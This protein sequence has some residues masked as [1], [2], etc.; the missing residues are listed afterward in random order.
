[1]LKKIIV[2][3]LHAKYLPLMLMTLLRYKSYIKRDWNDFFFGDDFTSI[4]FILELWHFMSVLVLKIINIKC[5]LITRTIRKYENYSLDSLAWLYLGR[6]IYPGK[7]QLHSL[8]I[9]EFRGFQCSQ[10]FLGFCWWPET[11]ELY[12]SVSKISL[13][14]LVRNCDFSIL[15]LGVSIIVLLVRYLYL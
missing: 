10:L 12:K 8:S 15:K 11:L 6:I 4:I 5:S 1:M 14:N 3:G 2:Y 7:R 13:W 9:V